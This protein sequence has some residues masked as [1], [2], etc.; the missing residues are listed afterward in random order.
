MILLLQNIKPGMVLLILLVRIKYLWYFSHMDGFCT[1]LIHLVTTLFFIVFSTN[2]PISWYSDEV[3]V[4]ETLLHCSSD[5][6]EDHWLGTLALVAF[7]PAFWSPD[8][9]LR[10]LQQTKMFQQ[11]VTDSLEVSSKHS[12]INIM[13]QHTFRLVAISARYKI[14]ACGAAG[15]VRTKSSI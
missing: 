3:E 10:D 7:L 6:I 15:R 11:F 12:L 1:I 5:G 4:N 9:P 14:T 2:V 8:G 13:K